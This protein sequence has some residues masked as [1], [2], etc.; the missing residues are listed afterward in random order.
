MTSKKK[1]LK[2]THCDLA[3]RTE[4]TKRSQMIQEMRAFHASP[5]AHRRH[6][7]PCG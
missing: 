7:M 1:T 6:G 5:E 4:I 3:G 2:Q